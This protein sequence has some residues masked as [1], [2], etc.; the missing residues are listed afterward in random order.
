MIGHHRDRD[1]PLT[2]VSRARYRSPSGPSPAAR[3][4]L[5]NRLIMRGAACGGRR[6]SPSRSERAV[7]HRRAAGTI[8]ISMR[9]VREPLASA[10]TPCCPT[11]ASEWSEIEGDGET[12]ARRTHHRSWRS[13]VRG[14]C[15]ISVFSFL[16]FRRPQLDAAGRLRGRCNRL[17]T[18]SATSSGA[19]SIRRISTCRLAKPVATDPG[20][21]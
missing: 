11:S 1:R 15:R 7:S 10:D 12:S 21:T 19:I 8:A 2:R 6:S 16:R 14:A 9:A 20:M 17:M 13:R 18:T 5:P 3:E 4:L